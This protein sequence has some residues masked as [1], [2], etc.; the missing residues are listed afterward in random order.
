MVR[1]KIAALLSAFAVSLT[2]AAAP[3]SEQYLTTEISAYA[4]AGDTDNLS[5]YANE[6]FTLVNKERAAKG[7][8]PLKL[9]GE[10]SKAAN[11]RAKEIQTTFSHT[12]PDGRSCFT[13]IKEA[14]ISY[15]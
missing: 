10:L 1:K 3:V 14:G 8:S 2:M 6:V 7:L 15:T 9:S 13:A 12:R 5:Q 4:A 11:V